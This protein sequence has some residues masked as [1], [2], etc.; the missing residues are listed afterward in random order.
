MLA[1][2]HAQDWIGT[3]GVA[4]AGPP[5]VADAMVLTDQTLRLIVRTSIGGKHLIAGYQQVIARAC[6]GHRCVWGDIDPVPGRW[7]LLG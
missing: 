1:P 2:A 3:W 6:A 4:P 5:A 7:L